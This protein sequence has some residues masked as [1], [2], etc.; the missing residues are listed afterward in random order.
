MKTKLILL[1]LFGLMGCAHSLPPENYGITVTVAKKPA[2]EVTITPIKDLPKVQGETVS[3]AEAP[4][5]TWMSK[6]D[7]DNKAH[8][9]LSRAIHN[10]VE[11]DACM[12][13]PGDP[14]CSC[15]SGDAPEVKLAPR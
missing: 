11:R 7:I 14:L 9:E 3:E 10:A 15:I 8:E 1:S 6:E 4:I 12:C 5:H 2:R 13:S